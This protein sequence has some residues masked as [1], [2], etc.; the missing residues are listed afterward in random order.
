MILLTLVAF[1]IIL[2]LLIFVHELGH[3]IAARKS[4]MEVEEF[5]FGFPPRLFG[6]KRGN[7][8][9]SINAIPLGGFVK[10]KGENGEETGQGSF[11]SAPAIRRFIT[12]IA[13]VAMNA[14]LA[15]IL[16][17]IA[18]TAGMPTLITEG[19]ELSSRAK[20]REAK[21]T[22]LLIAEESP[23]DKAGLRAGDAI[24]KIDG[25]PVSSFMQAQDL[26][27]LK[28]GE[29]VNYTI[30]RGSESFETQIIPRANPPE[31][32]GPLGVLLGEVAIVS[33]PW[34]HSIAVALTSLFSL[35]TQILVALGTFLKNLVTDGQALGALTGPIGIAVLTRDALDIG[36]VNVIYFTALLSI[37]LAII[38]VLPFPALDGGRILFLLIEKIRGRKLNQVFEQYANMIGFLLLITLM[39][40]VT[41]KDFGRFSG[42][43]NSLWDRITN[44]L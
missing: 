18:L 3:F 20:I 26:T 22:M 5:G 42:E 44:L 34:Y 31:G 21:V 25:V 27:G 38:N 15:W 17:S 40:W 33:Y 29:I 39:V 43:L 24:V 12:L 4:G 6:I 1:L 36:F 14:L 13:G 28:A 16:L 9:Y 37:N 7:T 35:T 2:G 19:E 32:E 8:V 23:A 10:I 30:E 11:A 41:V